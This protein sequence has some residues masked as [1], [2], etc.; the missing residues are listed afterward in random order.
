[1]VLLIHPRGSTLY[2]H[3]KEQL[4]TE[5]R[6]NFVSHPSCWRKSILELPPYSPLLKVSFGNDLNF[7]IRKVVLGIAGTVK[8][9]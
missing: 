5:E 3:G 1:M 7:S 2:E 9:S 6:R 8:K 4:V